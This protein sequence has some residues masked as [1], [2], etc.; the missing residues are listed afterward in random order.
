MGEK[1]I[2]HHQMLIH[3]ARQRHCLIFLMQ[4][5]RLPVI[6]KRDTLAGQ[7]MVAEVCRRHPLQERI[8]HRQPFLLQLRLI[9][10]DHMTDHVRH[11]PD[12][13]VRQHQTALRPL[14]RPQFLV[15]RCCHQGSH[16]LHPHPFKLNRF[17][18]FHAAKLQLFPSRPNLSATFSPKQAR[19]LTIII[20]VKE[21]CLKKHTSFCSN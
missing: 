18:F 16:L 21:T 6:L 1:E 15:Q 20:N 13:Q 5:E 11:H 10:H 4:V 2:E 12:H 9:V 3:R 14:F 8:G 19:S 17:L 7:F